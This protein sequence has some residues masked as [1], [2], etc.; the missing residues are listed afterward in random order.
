MSSWTG[1]P[2]AKTRSASSSG[3]DLQLRIAAEREKRR[4]AHEQSVVEALTFR[5]FIQKV[6]PRYQF[7]RH[8]EELIGVLQRVADGELRRV[9]VFLPPRHSKSETVS[10]LFPAYY[11][12]RHPDRFVGIAS[13]GADLAYT[14][15]RSARDHYER[16]GGLLHRAAKAVKYWLTRLLGGLWAAGVGGPATGKGYH[17]GIVDDPL[18][19]WKEASSETIRARI[20][21]WWSTVWATREEPGGAQVIV[22]TR[23]HEDDLS[24]WLLTLELEAI[25]E[26]DEPE[27]WYIVNLPAIADPDDSPTYPASCTVHADWRAAG[28]A[29]CP[30]RYPLARLQRMRRRIGEFFFGALFQQRP[31]PRDGGLFS[32]SPEIVAVVPA[33]VFRVR[34][35]DKAGAAPGKGDWTVGVLLA[36][37]RSEGRFYVEDVVRGQWPASE[38]NKKMREIAELDRQTYGHVRHYI[39]QPPGLAKEATD[40]VIQAMNGYPVFAEPVKGDKIE[41]AEP[42]A[43]QWQAGN[44]R[45]VSGAWNKA[46]L[47]EHRGFPS[48]KFDDQVDGSSGAH[49]KV[50]E[51]AAY[52]DDEPIGS[53]SESIFG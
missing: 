15:S 23:W 19:D 9:M 31:R 16:G 49:R 48:A 51:I 30:E 20:K 21:D 33:G 52:D 17:L 36:Y 29:L 1:S 7:Y 47:E 34:Y 53:F 43:A 10:R 3:A 11:L 42:W 39:E 50:T 41:R 6:N 46:Y 14:L 35:W 26:D 40:A 27:R 5:E 2:P 8:C 44:V 18:K 37:D 32:G 24:G 4:R 38:R 12:Y 25:A 22:Q 45:L 28:E 13:Y